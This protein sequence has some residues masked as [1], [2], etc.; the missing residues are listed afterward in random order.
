MLRASPCRLGVQSI[1]K[2]DLFISRRNHQAAKSGFTRRVGPFCWTLFLTPETKISVLDLIS[3]CDTYKTVI[4]GIVYILPV[5]YPFLGQRNPR[6][7]KL[8][9]CVNRQTGGFIYSQYRCRRAAYTRGH[10]RSLD[11]VTG[12]GTEGLG[13]LARRASMLRVRNCN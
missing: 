11:A 3:T 10:F 7:V 1:G 12:N 4:Q 5:K 6:L 13:K 2:A 8:G 9:S